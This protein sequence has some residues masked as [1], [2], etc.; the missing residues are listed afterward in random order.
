MQFGNYLYIVT[1]AVI[2]GFGLW[3]YL[4]VPRLYAKHAADVA[5]REPVMGV[6]VDYELDEEDNRYTRLIEY[7]VDGHR[8]RM[9]GWDT[10]G[11]KGEPMAPVRLAYRRDMRSDAIEV[12]REFSGDKLLGMIGMGMGVVLILAGVF[13]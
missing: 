1:G 9:S 13:G 8:Y 7:E 2:A 5:S 4:S 12:E 6:V 11:E 10:I 3:G